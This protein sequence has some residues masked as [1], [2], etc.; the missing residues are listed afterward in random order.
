MAWPLTGGYRLK[1]L[2]LWSAAVALAN[3][4]WAWNS[5]WRWGGGGCL[6]ATTDGLRIHVCCCRWIYASS[7]LSATTDAVPSLGETSSQSNLKPHTKAKWNPV[8]ST[9]SESGRS[10][11][12]ACISFSN[13]FSFPSSTSSSLLL[14][15]LPPSM[16]LV[17]LLPICLRCYDL[18]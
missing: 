14:L 16:S 11:T 4:W 10:I 1:S 5:K 8:N 12:S 3:Q 18:C 15:L 2:Q 17:L 13:V 6:H 9:A 7:V